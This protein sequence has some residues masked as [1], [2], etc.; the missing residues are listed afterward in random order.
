MY[1][2]W[3]GTCRVCR[4][5]HRFCLGR[6]FLKALSCEIREVSRA[7]EATF[8]GC[9]VG[10]P[11]DWN[12]TSSVNSLTGFNRY[13][14]TLTRRLFWDLGGIFV[15]EFKG[16]PW[17]FERQSVIFLLTTLVGFPHFDDFLHNTAWE[18]FKILCLKSIPSL[19]MCLVVKTLHKLQPTTY[20]LSQYQ[21]MLNVLK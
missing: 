11:R 4:S 18:H 2:T 8:G 13:S 3:T 7:E 9:Q 14:P 17:H 19:V 21:R 6:C 20:L 16:T 5:V 12:C 15:R 1:K 10:C